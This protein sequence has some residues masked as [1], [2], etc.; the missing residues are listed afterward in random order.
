MGLYGSGRA[1]RFAL[2]DVAVEGLPLRLQPHDGLGVIS[3]EICRFGQMTFSIPGIAPGAGAEP[4]PETDGHSIMAKLRLETSRAHASIERSPAMR[5]IF[6]EGYSLE[7]Y[8]SLR[9]V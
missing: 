2:A 4:S 8:R 3:A 6:S 9:C 7:N 1:N 5:A